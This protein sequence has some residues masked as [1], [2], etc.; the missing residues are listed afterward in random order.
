[1]VLLCLIAGVIVYGW[2]PLTVVGLDEPIG[3]IDSGWVESFDGG[4]AED[5]YLID[6]LGRLLAVEC[7]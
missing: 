6:K 1:M 5:D 4:D 2:K 3:L 7:Q